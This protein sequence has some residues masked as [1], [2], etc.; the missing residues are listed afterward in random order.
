MGKLFYYFY[1][2]RKLELLHTHSH[3]FHSIV[4]NFL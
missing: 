1:E 4:K 3:L 2:L